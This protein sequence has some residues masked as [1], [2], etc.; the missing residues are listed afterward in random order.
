MFMRIPKTFKKEFR[1]QNFRHLDAF[2]RAV[3]AL[4]NMV[5]LNQTK[6][7]NFQNKVFLKDH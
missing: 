4:K 1:L 5:D 3:A 6:D 2:S 7:D